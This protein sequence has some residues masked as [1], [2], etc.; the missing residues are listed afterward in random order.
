MR[1]KKPLIAVALVVSMVS[2]PVL[3]QPVAPLSLARAGAT[4]ENESSLITEEQALIPGLILIAVMAAAILL[5]KEQADD[6]DLD[7]PVSP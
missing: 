2:A 7:N 1:L 5:S 4:M 3:A 6:D